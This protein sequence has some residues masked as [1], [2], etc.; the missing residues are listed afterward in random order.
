MPFR[1]W[2]KAERKKIL[3][4]ENMAS[5]IVEMWRQSMNLSPDYAADIRAFWKLPDDFRF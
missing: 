3:K 1:Q 4:G 5:A 2:W